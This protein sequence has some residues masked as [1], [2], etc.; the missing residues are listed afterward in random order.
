MFWTVNSGRPFDEDATPQVLLL[1]DN[2]DSFVHNLDRYFVELGHETDFVR[3][4]D[5]RLLSLNPRS[6]S[7]LVISPGPC[8]PDEAGHCLQLVQQWHQTVP[9]LGICLGHQ[10]IVQALGGRVVR[11]GHPVHGLTS[12]VQ[13]NGEGL[14]RGCPNPLEATRYHSLIAERSSLPEQFQIEA[15]L[16]EGTIMGVKLKDAPVWGLQFHPESVLTACG[17]QLL[18]NFCQLSGIEPTTT[19]L[20]SVEPFF[21]F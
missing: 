13:H 1:I 4:D 21:D 10:V 3:N 16:E 14:F 7:G 2:Y 20:Q 19:P 6:Y 9:I 5:P 18:A 11:S 17:H 15:E 12:Q 8:T